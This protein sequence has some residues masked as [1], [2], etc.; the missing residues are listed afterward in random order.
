MATLADSPMQTIHG[1]IIFTGGPDT[2]GTTLGLAPEHI[3]GI[4]PLTTRIRHHLHRCP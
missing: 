3:A 2:N 1:P 4:T